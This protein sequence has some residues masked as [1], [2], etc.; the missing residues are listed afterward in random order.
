[1]RVVFDCLWAVATDCTIWQ[2]ITLCSRRA[3]SSASST[4]KT[5]DCFS[6]CPTV[7]NDLSCG[8]TLNKL[9]AAASV[10]SLLVFCMLEETI[11]LLHSL[12]LPSKATG[13][14]ALSESRHQTSLPE[15]TLML[16]SRSLRACLD[17]TI[18][19]GV[20]KVL[21]DRSAW[22]SL[23]VSLIT[24]ACVMTEQR[25]KPLVSRCVA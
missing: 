10:R 18:E 16:A 15:K 23:W 7:L 12:A 22:S 5:S 9:R 3:P 24:Q 19:L 1:M 11:S 14:T 2:Y 8:P 21:S 17:N 13:P 20:E 4:V 25:V 6:D